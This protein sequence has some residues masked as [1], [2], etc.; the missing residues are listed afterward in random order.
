M[1]CTKVCFGLCNHVNIELKDLKG[2]LS[3]VY[4]FKNYIHWLLSTTQLDLIIKYATQ[5]VGISCSRS[6]RNHIK[7]DIF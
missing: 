5:T 1:C 3:L 7:A 4:K 2:G 6:P